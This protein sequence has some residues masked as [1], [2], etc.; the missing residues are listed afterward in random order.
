MQ[1]YNINR[2]NN[3]SQRLSPKKSHPRYYVLSQITE[4]L[5]YIAEKY[6]KDKSVKKIYDYGCGI[7]PYKN[8]FGKYAEE[9]IGIDLPG[10]TL[11][12][13]IIRPDGS[14]N[15]EDQTADIVLSNQVLEHVEDPMEYLSEGWRMLKK[16]GL[17]ICSTHGYWKYHPDPNDYWRWTGEGLRK[18]IK[19]SGF[20]VLET[21]GVCNLASIS[22]ILLQ[23]ALYYKIKKKKIMISIFQRLTAYFDKKIKGDKENEASVFLIVAKKRYDG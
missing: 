13:I 21:I 4:K 23:D 17:L 8:I 15:I 10:N 20:E 6:V 7:M 16:D 22:M 5:I 9:Y 14:V 1:E 2:E 18:I 19:D 3:I 12:D 11:A